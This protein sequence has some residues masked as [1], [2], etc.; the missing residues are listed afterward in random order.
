MKN[1][2]LLAIALASVAMAPAAD[3]DYSYNSENANPTWYGTNKK[4]NYHVAIKIDNPALVGSKILGITVPVNGEA[5]IYANPKAFMTSEL[6]VER[7]DGV[8]V[9]VA[10]ICTVDATI[11]DGVLT[12]TFAEPYTITADPLYVGYSIDVAELTAES[13]TPVAVVPGNKPEGFWFFSSR[14][15]LKWDSYVNKSPDGYQSALTVHIDGNFP[16]ASAAVQ[17][18]ERAVMITGQ[19]GEYTFNVVNAGTDPIN[20]IEILSSLDGT[21]RATTYTFDTPIPNTLGAVAT[22]TIEIP[23]PEEAEF[24]AKEINVT[25]EKVNG[26]ENTNLLASASSK[27]IFAKSIPTNRPLVEEYTGL[28][29]GWC[30]RGYVALEHMAENYGRDFVAAAWHNGDPMQI[31]S[32]YPNSVSGFP[33]AY[34]N[35]TAG[36]DPGDIYTYWPKF[37]EEF[38]DISIDCSVEYTDEEETTIR[39]TA[40]VT[41]ISDDSNPYY[42]GYL[43]IADGLRSK[44]WS[45]SNY[46]SGQPQLASTLP[47]PYGKMFVNGPSHVPN[48]EFNDVVISK[49]YAMG[50]DGSLPTSLKAFNTESHT[51]TFDISDIRNINVR[52]TPENP[53]ANVI[54]IHKDKIRVVAFV[55]RANGSVIN[56]CSSEHALSAYTGVKNVNSEAEVASTAWY[57]LQGR[58]LA[59]PVKGELN[60]CVETL[61]D[62]TTRASKIMIK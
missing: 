17:L 55:L 52:P 54:P 46:Y 18:P 16:A 60:V 9:N 61:T 51:V 59:A 23:V 44:N 5:S 27:V 43:L 14:T 38:T 26:V 29:C 1:Y 4:E 21:C 41:S 31:S 22:A 19:T 48:L 6:V 36:L 45:Q 24:G 42:I 57:D 33:Y 3:M 30:V 39:A 49:D 37:R 56:S 40:N 50:V 2:Y 53:D 28:W 47:E 8:R 7:V 62:G 58:S 25:I 11:A 15:Q 10:D 34:I 12:A 35:R 32:A 13:K 20:S